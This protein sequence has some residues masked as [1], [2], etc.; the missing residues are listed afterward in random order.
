MTKHALERADRVEVLRC[1]RVAADGG[2]EARQ[3]GGREVGELA[4]ALEPDLA[5]ATSSR[6]MPVIAPSIGR[7]GASR[8]YQE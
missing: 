2:R 5:A 8:R 6:T 3:H 1:A 4:R 7:T